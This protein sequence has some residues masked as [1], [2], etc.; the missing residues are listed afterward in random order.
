VS[1]TDAGRAVF[2]G[3]SFNQ[4]VRYSSYKRFNV[5]AEKEKLKTSG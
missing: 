4:T 2:V 1:S 5:E 3:F